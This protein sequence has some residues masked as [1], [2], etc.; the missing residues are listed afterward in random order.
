[1]RA[2]V[3]LVLLAACGRFE[4]DVARDGGGSAEGSDGGDDSA[5]CASATMHDEDGDG[6]LDE[7]DVCPQDADPAQA[8]GDG[9]GVGDVCDPNPLMPGDTIAFF[10]PFITHNPLWE[11]GGS[12]LPQWQDD[13]VEVDARNSSGGMDL[14]L[15]FANDTVVARAHALGAAGTQL[16]FALGDAKG[17]TLRFCELFDSTTDTSPGKFA[18]TYTSDGTNYGTSATLAIMAPLGSVTTL[19]LTFITTATRSRASRMSLRHHRASPAPHRPASAAKHWTSPSWG[20]SCASIRSR[21]TTRRRP[22]TKTAAPPE[23]TRRA[24]QSRSPEGAKHPVVI[25]AC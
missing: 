10:D 3:A 21:T 17:Q 18:I 22:K 4:F 15:V 6:V 9:D 1:M 16:Q 13:Y 23:E 14:P 5:M 2:A 25:S 7:C 24:L 19:T 12:A 11:P 8:D 20:S